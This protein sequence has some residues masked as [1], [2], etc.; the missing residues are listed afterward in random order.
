MAIKILQDIR[1]TYYT[2]YNSFE[3]NKFKMHLL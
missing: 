1:L 2:H 3:I